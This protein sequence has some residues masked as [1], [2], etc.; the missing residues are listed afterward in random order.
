M[1][2]T[3]PPLNPLPLTLLLAS[4]LLAGCNEEIVCAAGEAECGGRCVSTL[5]DPAHCGACGSACGAD[6]ACVGGVCAPGLCADGA[7]DALQVAC[8][9]TNDV[10]PARADLAAV[11]PPR[12][13]AL[14]PIALAVHD[15]VVYV[16]TALSGSASTQSTI[17]ILPLDRRLAD[18]EKKLA[19]ND[20]EFV[21]S[22]E[23]VLFVANSGGGTVIAWDP[24]RD[25]VLDE[26]VFGGRTDTNPRAIAFAGTRAFVPLYG[27]D[28]TTAG[29]A[30]GV[31]DLSDLPACAAATGGASPPC[32][33]VEKVIDL[34]ANAA[35][36]DPPGLPFPSRV[37]V[38]GGKILVTLAN[39][40]AETDGPLAGFYINPAG[41]G[42][43]AVVDTTNEDALS[44]VRLGPCENP[45]AIAVN[46]TEAWVSCGGGATPGLLRIDLSGA[47]PVPEAAV[48]PV[49]DLGLGAPGN[50]A[51]CGGMGYVTDLW[52]GSVL[53]FDPTG[54]AAPSTTSVCPVSEGPFGYAWAA[55]VACAP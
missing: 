23:G 48:R 40:K 11:G 55:D 13:T 29:Q 42:R 44:I 38:A 16:A 46:G 22:H 9:S 12:P 49:A 47:A 43:L 53:R 4:L 50:L 45:G 52:S 20:F 14:G 30:I 54:A 17:S 21:A 39:L 31:L 7:C 41:P 10:R 32:G 33:A 37:A 3:T 25:R 51:F 34:R 6:D 8:F 35:A 27:E 18:S 1:K 26:Y 24:A 19:G 15:G 2:T 36:F 5:S 28:P